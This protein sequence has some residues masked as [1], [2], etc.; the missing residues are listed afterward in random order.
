MADIKTM[1][2]PGAPAPQELADMKARAQLKNKL[3]SAAL[4]EAVNAA[5]AQAKASGEFDGAP[6]DPGY[7]PV[8]DKD[9]FDGKDGVSPTV[10]VSDISG[11]HRVSITDKNG[12]KTVDVM[13]GE[14]GEPG[15]PGYTPVKGADYWTPADQEGIVQQVIAALGT[16]VF[17]RVDENKVVTLTGELADGTYTFRYEDD[18]GN[19]HL[20]G[21]YTKAP[22]PKY[23][24]IIPLS[25]DADGSVFNGTGYIDGY[26]LS[27]NYNT[28]APHY[29]SAQ[30]GYFTTG[31]I[32]YTLEDCVNC[33]PFYVK[34]VNLDT[35]E[36]ETYARMAMYTD[37]TSTYNSAHTVDLKTTGAAG[38][39]ITKLG[40]LYYKI[41]P[42]SGLYNTG[43]TSNGWST[44]NVTVAKFSLPGSG[45]G[46]IFTID[47]P[48]D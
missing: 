7:T 45:A 36:T 31:F 40:D 11:G 26:R 1:W 43:G 44:K 3:D 9:Y 37:H 17:G 4:P 30:S 47:E 16:P 39:T 24:N 27:S 14:K 8:K 19:T 34:G 5:L 38:F 29:A 2:L 33:V 42:G 13:N 15:A 6:G 32:P 12:T 23:T 22:K 41:T 46:V 28:N 48:I 25:I 18:D 35:L 10:A 21:T 20:L